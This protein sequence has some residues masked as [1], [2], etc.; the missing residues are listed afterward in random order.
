MVRFLEAVSSR[1]MRL[2]LET[3]TWFE[4]DGGRGGAWD[5]TIRCPCY[6]RAVV[7]DWAPATEAAA[8]EIWL[9]IWRTFLS[10]LDVKDRL[11]W[12]ETF[13]DWTFYPAKKGLQHREN[14]AG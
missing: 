4:T 9:R 13:L 7:Q 8:Q 2:F 3:V 6:E 14:Q 10:E 1:A 11:R 12:E 5:A